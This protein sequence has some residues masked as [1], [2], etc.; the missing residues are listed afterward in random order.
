MA[1]WPSCSWLPSVCVLGG[2]LLGKLHVEEQ[3]GRFPRPSLRII[4]VD[5]SG[6][7][8]GGNAR[9]GNAWLLRLSLA[10]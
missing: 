7:S 6:G 4:S 10:R 5:A 8:V 9:L 1:T 2:L 3:R